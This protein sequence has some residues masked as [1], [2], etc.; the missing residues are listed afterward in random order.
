[1]VRAVFVPYY[2]RGPP[3]Y[4]PGDIVTSATSRR[5]GTV[6]AAIRAVAS[7]DWLR[8]VL[9]LAPEARR[10]TLG[11]SPMDRRQSRA[12]SPTAVD[13]TPLTSICS[14]REVVGITSE[15]YR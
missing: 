1:M 11:S 3:R 2:L 9:A 8:K 7:A 10:A 12:I 5:R 15:V 4:R 6:A 14:C 13:S